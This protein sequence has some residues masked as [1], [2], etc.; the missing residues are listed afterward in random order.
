[1]R[2]NACCFNG[3]DL[4]GLVGHYG[5][6]ARAILDG[7][8]VGEG[9]EGV[10]TALRREF[11]PNVVTRVHTVDGE[12]LLVEYDDSDHGARK[13]KA[14]LRLEAVGSRVVE[15]RIDHDADLVRRLVERATQ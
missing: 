2:R 7:R 3:R 9:P 6:Q 8:L 10:T 1:M 11:G 14:V 4:D 15:V 13:P 12:P 5:P